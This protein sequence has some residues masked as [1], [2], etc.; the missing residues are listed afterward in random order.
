MSTKF[1]LSIFLTFL[2]MLMTGC[3]KKTSIQDN[4]LQVMVSI[5]PQRFVV[6]Q[7]AGD[8]VDVNVMIP[9]GFSPEVYEPNPEQIKDL[10]K[11][12][13]YFAIGSAVDFEK[14]NLK[15][16]QEINPKMKLIKTTDPNDLI[17]FKEGGIDP[18][19]WLDPKLVLKSAEIISRSLSDLDPE[20][21]DI[22][23]QNLANFSQKI[24]DLDR[25][26]T[27]KFSTIKGKSILIYHPILGYLAK[28]Y[29]FSQD[30]IEIDGKSPDVKQ[31]QSIISKAIANKIRYIFVEKQF[32]THSSQVIAEQIGAS[33]VTIDP[34]AEDY[35][36]NIRDISEK[37]TKE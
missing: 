23:T 34:L 37:L 29:G 10:A 16:F 26:L 21:K 5:L 2:M 27:N 36:Q 19:V 9:Q 12:D 13:V 4:K 35:F 30:Y 33:L 25:E 24:Q 15:K 3:V 14:T 17:K 18:H 6:K 11:A 1:K 32:Q 28:S 31:M 7:I 20:H 22:Y 8:L